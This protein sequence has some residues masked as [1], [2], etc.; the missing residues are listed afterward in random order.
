M[1][2]HARYAVI[3]QQLSVSLAVYP[4]L[5]FSTGCMKCNQRPI[6]VNAATDV[7][8]QLPATLIST[9]GVT[10]DCQYSATKVTEKS[11][12]ML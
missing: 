8:T 1:R 5:L 7:S 6:G 12:S 11:L 2:C 4:F 3:G 9:Y 10:L